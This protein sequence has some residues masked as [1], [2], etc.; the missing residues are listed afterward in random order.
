M[1]DVIRL[2]AERAVESFGGSDGV[3]NAAGF[4]QA[5]IAMS[6]TSEQID[7]YV[8]RLMLAGRSDVE[9]LKGGAHFRLVPST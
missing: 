3:F 2:A 7:G 9:P 8:V 4:S 5:F 6:P 1:N